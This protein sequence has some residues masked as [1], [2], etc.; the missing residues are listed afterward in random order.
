MKL[1]DTDRAIEVLIE[2]AC[3]TAL[4]QSMTEEEF[5][6]EADPESIEGGLARVCRQMLAERDT[7]KS[8]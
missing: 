2:S 6:E 4:D 8:D 5:T 1:N 3:R 7:E